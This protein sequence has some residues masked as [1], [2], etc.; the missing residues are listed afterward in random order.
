MLKALFPSPN[1]VQYL[2]EKLKITKKIQFTKKN[3]TVSC[4][5]LITFVMKGQLL[6]VFERWKNTIKEI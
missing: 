4:R 5:F 6:K 1:E 2:N 3:I